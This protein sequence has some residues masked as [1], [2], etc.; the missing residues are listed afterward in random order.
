MRKSPPIS[1]KSTGSES[2]VIV[3]T[4]ESKMIAPNARIVINIKPI[5]ANFLFGSS[6]FLKMS[7]LFT[8]ITVNKIRTAI[9][10]T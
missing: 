5:P 9:E 1:L 2:V 8:S 3:L 10:P 7:S 6:I 4:P